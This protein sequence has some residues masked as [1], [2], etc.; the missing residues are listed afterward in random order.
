MLAEDQAVVGSVAA[1]IERLHRAD[2]AYAHLFSP[3]HDEGLAQALRRLTITVRGEPLG[4]IDLEV[5][6][7]P[8]YGRYLLIYSTDVPKIYRRFAKR[9]GMGHVI[10][11]HVTEVSYL[12]LRNDF[13]TYEE[14]GADVFAIADLVPAW[15]IEELRRSRV[16]WRQLQHHVCRALRRFT[17]NWPEDRVG[18]RASLRMALYR[19]AGL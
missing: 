15:Q 1:S 10:G 5:V 13:M 8:V 17:L 16:G 2:I 18:D 7:P 9:H 12:S 6:T 11:G 3:L 19:Q 14:R 4:T